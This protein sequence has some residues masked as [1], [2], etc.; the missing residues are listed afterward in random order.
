MRLLTNEEAT[1]NLPTCRTLSAYQS[2]GSTSLTVAT[3]Q[4]FADANALIIPVLAEDVRSD[5]D[6]PDWLPLVD[7]KVPF[8]PRAYLVAFLLD[9][10]GYEAA[11]S[12]AALAD[13]Q[14]MRADATEAYVLVVTVISQ[15]RNGVARLI[16]AFSERMEQHPA[17][18]RVREVMWYTRT[19]KGLAMTQYFQGHETGRTITRTF[20]NGKSQTMPMFTLA[21]SDWHSHVDKVVEK[22][23]GLEANFSETLAEAHAKVKQN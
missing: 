14:P 22:L 2:G 11:C 1:E 20:E 7:G 4:R 19:A 3:L 21:V 15:V 13:L 8:I 23:V 16:V 6:L 9:K 12:G 5:D 18:T 17:F 10:D